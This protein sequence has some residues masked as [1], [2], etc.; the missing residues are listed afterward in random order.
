MSL[1]KEEP[2]RSLLSDVKIV[3]RKF[4]SCFVINGVIWCDTIKRTSIDHKPNS[5][6]LIIDGRK[7]LH[8]R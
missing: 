2:T 4:K 8:V 1:P 3:D 5:W 6:E 7:R